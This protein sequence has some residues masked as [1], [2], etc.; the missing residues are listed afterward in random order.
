MTEGGFRF[1]PNAID[2]LD[3]I[4]S[5]IAID[6]VKAADRVEAEI[7]ETCERLASHPQSGSRRPWV[8]KL[9][10]RF[11][12]IARFP[13]YVVVYY[14]EVKPIQIVAVLHA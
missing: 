4:V 8:T 6:S 13:N 7:M 14:D 3:E 10:L 5:Y 9:P 1:A 2:D 12:T 11:Q